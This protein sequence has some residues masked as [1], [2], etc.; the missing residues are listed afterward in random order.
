MEVLLA[1]FILNFGWP[2]FGPFPRDSR[3]SQTLCHSV[4]A[5]P[6]TDT[7]VLSGVISYCLRLPTHALSPSRGDPLPLS[8]PLSTL[9]SFLFSLSSAL[10][11]YLSLSLALSLS[12]SLSL[13]LPSS[14]SLTLPSSLSLSLY[15][16]LHLPSHPLFN[17]RSLSLYPW[18]EC[19]QCV[20]L[21]RHYTIPSL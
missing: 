2:C 7:R 8:L 12:L 10:F 5:P 21:S 19:D 14:L 16:S 20:A 9:K 15:P 4:F 18:G 3:C 1:V 6:P 13:A 11:V 17:L